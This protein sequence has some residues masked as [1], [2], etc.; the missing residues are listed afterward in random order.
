AAQI[1]G[2]RL[3][4]QLRRIAQQRAEL[5][6]Q[7]EL[8]LRADQPFRKSSRLDQK[9]PVPARS[10]GFL[11]DRLETVEGRHD[12]EQCQTLDTGGM[13]ARQAVGDPRAAVMTG[14]GEA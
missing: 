6:A 3:R 1:F 2:E 9:E 5:V 8:G 7:K 14:D 11:V 12:V 4:L 10:R 13:I